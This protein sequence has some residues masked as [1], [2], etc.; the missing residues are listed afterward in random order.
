MLSTREILGV[1]RIYRC[2]VY[3]YAKMKA[4]KVPQ[5]ASSSTDSP[6]VYG[7]LPVHKFCVLVGLKS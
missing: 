1:Y 2:V 6:T 5:H 7:T 3:E 4:G